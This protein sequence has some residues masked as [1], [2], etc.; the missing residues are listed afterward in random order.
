VS[1][2]TRR[3]AARLQAGYYILTGIWP[4]AHRRSFERVTGPKVDFWLVRTVGVLVTAIGG[5]LALGA[6]RSIS[7]ELEATAI[8]AALG[9]AA[10]DVAEVA[11][12]HI[13]R[14]YLVDAVFELALAVTWR[15]GMR[16]RAVLAETP[17]G[18]AGVVG[19]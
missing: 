18:P 12:G 9:L 16:G 2:A 4:L 5:G 14:I 3:R 7:P 15:A 10:V 6:R 19:P 17:R 11:R 8:A 13:S 1:A